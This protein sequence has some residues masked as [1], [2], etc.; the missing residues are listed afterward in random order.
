MALIHQNLY[1]EEHLTAIETKRYFEDLLDQL[2]D[3]YNI[4]E[5]RITLEK[6]IGSFLIDVDTLIPLGLIT[7]ELISNALKHA[8]KGQGHG[9]IRFICI[10]TKDEIVISIRDNGVG[11]SPET[12]ATSASFGHK[13]IHAF[14]NKLKGGIEVR[15][16]QGTIIT[17]T[18]PKEIA[19][20]KRA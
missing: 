4:D 18:V 9:H 5:N 20:E 7:N 3:S 12:F 11:M 1:H 13:M 6:E 10:G 17:L 8:F 15:Q 16:D 19:G 2:F 14:V